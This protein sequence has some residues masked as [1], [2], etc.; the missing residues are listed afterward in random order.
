[1]RDITQRQFDAALARHGMRKAGFMGYVD[2]GV[3]GQ[4]I[5]VS[6]WNAGDRR[7]AQLAYL[8]RQRAWHEKRIAQRNTN[9]N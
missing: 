1:M 9:A 4:E 3:P 2:I 6:V 7:R 5:H 8:L